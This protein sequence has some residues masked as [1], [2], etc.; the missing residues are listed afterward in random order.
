MCRTSIASGGREKD[1]CDTGAE[2]AFKVELGEK[3][4]CAL[5][6]AFERTCPIRLQDTVAFDAY[7][8]RRR[9]PSELV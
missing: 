3:L 2:S 8:E 4:G 6:L 7:S 9:E 5:C 1:T